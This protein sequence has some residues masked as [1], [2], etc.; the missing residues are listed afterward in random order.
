MSKLRYRRL[1]MMENGDI[2]LK[3]FKQVELPE[4]LEEAS[5]KIAVIDTETTGLDSRNDHIIELGYIIVE[6]D[7]KFNPIKKGGK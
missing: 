4:N 7:K 5:F 2:L 3:F 1:G 6:V